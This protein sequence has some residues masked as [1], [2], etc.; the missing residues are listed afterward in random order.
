MEMVSEDENLNR[1]LWMSTQVLHPFDDRRCYICL[2]GTYWAC[3][4][5]ANPLRARRTS[6]GANAAIRGVMFTYLFCALQ[7]M[8]VG[9]VGWNKTMRIGWDAQYP[10]PNPSPETISKLVV[11]RLTTRQCSATRPRRFNSLRESRKDRTRQSCCGPRQ[12]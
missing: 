4:D 5:S 12:M 3:S 1:A 9:R 10:T 6:G 7:R 2:S 8:E 11:G